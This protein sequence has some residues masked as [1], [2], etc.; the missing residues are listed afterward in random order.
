MATFFITMGI[1]SVATISL[2]FACYLRYRDV[3]IR[4]ERRSPAHQSI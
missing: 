1:L 4:F 3:Q 2:Q